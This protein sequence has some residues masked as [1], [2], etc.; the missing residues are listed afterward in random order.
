MSTYEL[1]EGEEAIRSHSVTRSVSSD[2][3]N[4]FVLILNKKKVL[5]SARF[6]FMASV[7][8]QTHTAADTD[9]VHNT[10]IIY[11]ER[12]LLFLLLLFVFVCAADVCQLTGLCISEY[13]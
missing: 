7:R 12:A 9:R 6:A 5:C 3:G 13:R 4:L 11:Y 2:M 10:K 1:C 8:K